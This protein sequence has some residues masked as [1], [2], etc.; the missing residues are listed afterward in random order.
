[1]YPKEARVKVFCNDHIVKLG[2]VAFSGA[3]KIAANQGYQNTNGE[4]EGPSAKT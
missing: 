4:V 1:M 3:M 2:L